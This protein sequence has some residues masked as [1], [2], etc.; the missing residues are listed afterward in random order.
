MSATNDSFNIGNFIMDLVANLH[1]WLKGSGAIPAS[2]PLEEVVL[3]NLQLKEDRLQNILED[4][5]MASIEAIESNTKSIGIVQRLLAQLGDPPTN[6]FDR[7]TQRRGQRIRDLDL[8]LE[9]LQNQ[10]ISLFEQ[11]SQVFGEAQEVLNTQAFFGAESLTD[12][13]ERINSMGGSV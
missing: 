6:E 11:R 4:K 3:R 2:D 5:P 12:I 1:T 10:R 8:R 9:N 13:R 7:F